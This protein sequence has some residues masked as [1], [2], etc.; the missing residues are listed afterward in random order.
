M[1]WLPSLRA[2]AFSASHV[3][4]KDNLVQEWKRRVNV[5]PDEQLDKYKRRMNQSVDKLGKRWNDAKTVTLK[6][7][8]SFVSAV[9]NIFISAY[10][11]GAYPEYF[12]YW[13]TIQLAYGRI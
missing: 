6:E 2:T 13:Y 4:C 5:Q 8:I 11:I 3:S 7:K 9:L 12:H 1:Q 10:L